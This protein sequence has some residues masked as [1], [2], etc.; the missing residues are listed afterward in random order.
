M[1]P[2]LSLKD[3][4]GPCGGSMRCLAAWALAAALLLCAPAA[5][6]QAFTRHGTLFRVGP[7]PSSIAAADLNDDGL[8]EIVTADR[9]ELSNPREERPANDELSLL[10]AHPGLAY[11]KHHPS[12]KTGFGPYDVELANIDA[13]KWP[14]IVVVSFH[15]VRHR[16]VNLFLN[17]KQEG[18]FEKVDFRMPEERL[19]YFRHGDGDGGGIFTTPGLT[20]LAIK[21][22]NGDG[23]RDLVATGWSSDVL[24]LMPGH[25]ETHFAAPILLQAPGGPRDVAIADLNGDGRDDLAVALYAT[26]E[27]AIFGGKGKLEFEEVAR[28][29]TRGLLPTTLRVSDVDR[30]G[31]LDL[32]V[33]HAHADDSIVVFYGDGGFRYGVSQE[34][35]LGKDR[36]VLEHEIRDFV[37]EDITG[38]G[39][40]DFA[41]ACFA[42]GKVIVLVNTS[43]DGA[44]EQQ[45]DREVYSFGEGEP[46]ALCI[47]DFN[48]DG[49]KDLAVA[50][51]GVDSV[52]LLLGKG[53]GE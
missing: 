40:T 21:D 19:S 2:S 47:S 48:G 51:W 39:K 13:L 17:L 49:K 18:I 27:A 25:A 30:N 53:G 6:A 9:G 24:I 44:L 14:D 38:D 4:L 11:E 35:M 22:L 8:P 15:A 10:V 1:S 52:A 23:L 36:L 33:S 41:A 45:F 16:N 3:R 37:A 28:F 12:L 43:E 26:G 7:N 34:L 32:A 31:I 50:L 20:S 42:S 29:P 5:G 46:R